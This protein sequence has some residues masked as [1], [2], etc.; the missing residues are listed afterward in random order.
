MTKIQFNNH[1]SVKFYENEFSLLFM[2]NRIELAKNQ[3]ERGN[4]NKKLIFCQKIRMKEGQ[5]YSTLRV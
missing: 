5:V 4:F 1:S 2:I 3:L